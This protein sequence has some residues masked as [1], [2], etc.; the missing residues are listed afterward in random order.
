M[1]IGRGSR[2][3]GRSDVSLDVLILVVRHRPKAIGLTLAGDGWV[4]VAELLRPLAAHGRQLDLAALEELVAGSDKQRF[5]FSSDRLMIRAN[6]RHSVRVDLL[7]RFAARSTALVRPSPRHPFLR[8][9]QMAR[10]VQVRRNRRS[11]AFG[12][13]VQVVSE[14]L[15]KCFSASGIRSRVRDSGM[16][17]LRSYGTPKNG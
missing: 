5:A 10:R 3:A 7:H 11:G 16:H 12:T 15:F 14:R 4:P 2:N 6:Q 17:A 9:G 1:L 13:S 8:A